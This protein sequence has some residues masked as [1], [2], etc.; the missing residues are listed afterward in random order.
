MVPL[1]LLLRNFLCYRE[2]PNGEPLT[3]DLSGVHVVCLSGENGAGKSSLLDAITWALWGE[4]RASDDELVTQGEMQ[5]VVELV[6]ALNGREHRVIRTRTRGKTT[7]KGTQSAGK[8]TLDFQIKSDDGNWR[9][10]SFTTIR[11]T[12]EEINRALKMSYRTFINASFLLQGRADEFTASTPAERKQVLAEIL[13]LSA[14]TKLESAARERSRMLQ[15]DLHGLK[16][17]IEAIGQTAGMLDYWRDQ[18]LAAEQR[19]GELQTLH[20]TAVSALEAVALQIRQLEELLAQRRELA[21]RSQEMRS[22]IDHREAEVSR[23]QERMNQDQVL[24]RRAVEITTGMQQLRDA[25]QQLAELDRKRDEHSRL[26]QDRSK[27]AERWTEVRTALKAEMTQ[28]QLQCETLREQVAEDHRLAAEELRLTELLSA[29]HALDDELAAAQQQRAA[30]EAALQERQRQVQRLQHLREQAAQQREQAIRRSAEL[31]QRLQR[32]SRQLDTR[33]A[34]E[35]RLAAADQAAAGLAPAEAQLQRARDAEQALRDRISRLRADLRAGEAETARL[36]TAES[37]LQSGSGPCPVC[38]RELD[39]HAG[40]QAL[41]HYTAERQRLA[42]QRTAAETEL[43]AT[44]GSLPAAQQAVAAAE[45]Q[46][47]QLRTTAQSVTTIHEQLQQLAVLEEDAAGLRQELAA[48]STERGGAGTHS[49]E[50]AELEAT[51]RQSSEQALQAGLQQAG[52]AVTRLEQAQRERVRYDTER[53]GLRRRRTVLAPA[54]AQLQAAEAVAAALVQQYETQDFG[55]D[56]REAGQVIRAAMAALNFQR[57]DWEAVRDEVAGLGGWEEQQRKLELAEQRY[58]GDAQLV[59]QAQQ[60]LAHDYAAVQAAQ[61]Q[62]T[63]LDTQLNGLGDLRRQLT[64]LQREVT[65]RAQSLR[66]AE[67]E[68]QEQLTYLRAAE[69]AAVQLRELQEQERGTAARKE[70]FAELATA[71]GKS[72]VQAMLIETAI[73]QIEDEAN[74]LLGRLSD[75]QLH[76]TLD[77]QR[78]TKKG[79]TVE[80]LEIRIADG[81]GT[82]TYDAFSGGEA[83]RV[84]FALRIAL[85]RLLAQRAGAS[86]ETLVIDEGFGVL[87]AVGRERMIEAISSVQEAFKRIIVITHIDELKERFPATIE[88]RKTPQGSRWELR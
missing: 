35:A 28:A 18:A 51:L 62:I 1:R 14:Y 9:V 53:S 2:L 12:Q 44:T 8:S 41:Q 47:L 16:G 25:R 42:A 76:L 56:I 72:G 37:L 3:L 29:M 17:K 6:F 59:E 87:D 26:E 67:L 48:V 78:D 19:R 31:E 68:L 84:N 27:L 11:E 30:A 13:D 40:D 10:H 71:F 50:Q 81:L 88:V 70:L 82:R 46:L 20:S 85:S 24:R 77:T 22:R 83:L 54:T 64:D 5:T 38:R 69:S 34:L 86:L 79:D 55:H 60:L 23:L 39:Q 74:A 52:A 36:T 73:P 33:G 15:L 45:Q 58:D 61:L 57:S 63:G 49:S 43:A 7:S 75:G 32:L 66:G 80:T 21:G 4:A 65:Q